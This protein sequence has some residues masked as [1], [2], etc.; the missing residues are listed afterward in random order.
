MLNNSIQQ[1]IEELFNATPDNIGVGYGKKITNGEYTGEVGIVFHVEKKLPLEEIPSHEVLP[2]TV[3]VDG[4]TLNTDVIE[5][6]KVNFLVCNSETTSQCY[7]WQN[8]AP[9]N[10]NT[11]RPLQAGV[12][13]TSGNQQGTVGTLGLIA[14]D[15]A[16]QALVGITNNHVVTGNAFYT[17]QRNLTSATVNELYDPVFQNGDIQPSASNLMI[18][19]VIRYAPFVL[20]GFNYLDIAVCSIEDP[21]IISNTQSFKQFGLNYNTPM[22]FATTLEINSLLSTN[23][24]IYSSGRTSGV[25]GPGV[26][27]LSV[28]GVGVA[29]TVQPYT[30]SGYSLAVAILFGDLISFTRVDPQCPQ[31][32]ASGDSGSGLIA[33]FNGVWKIIGIVFAGGTSI[34]Y[35]CRIDRIAQALG[36]QAWDGSPKNFIN[37]TSVQ[38]KT[39]IGGSG[40]INLTCGGQTYWQI[41]STNV[42]NNPCI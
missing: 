38:Y 2:S 30:Y 10:R 21:S 27:R 28:S 29:T 40:D 31:P 5:V 11:I 4:V 41:G 12:S 37:P 15:V 1:K 39:V 42:I 26:C 13:F 34:G 16:T 23:P 6:G 25:K 17:N 18:G 24:E 20:S 9:A 8:T 32:I 19:R 35:A 3:E 7:G 22:P 14:V 36:V 33:N